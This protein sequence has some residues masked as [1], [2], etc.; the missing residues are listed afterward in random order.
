MPSQNLLL[1][2]YTGATHTLFAMEHLYGLHPI[3]AEDGQVYL[4]FD[5][6]K[7]GPMQDNI[8]AWVEMFEKLRKEHVT[9]EEYKNREAKFPSANE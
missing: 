5:I 7:C 2:L 1:T 3:T 8:Y 9:E 6:S 4:S